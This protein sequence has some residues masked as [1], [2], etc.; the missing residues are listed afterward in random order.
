MI[1]VDLFSGIGG[2]ALAAKAVGLQTVVF[3]EQDQ[4][5]KRVLNKNFKGI[6]VVPDVNEFDGTKY[7]GG[8]WT[9]GIPCQPFSTAGEKAGQS[10]RRFLWGQVLRVI[11]QGRP[12][13]FLL[14]N[15][16]GFKGLAADRVAA[17]L[18]GHGYSTAAVDLPAA[19]VGAPHRRHRIFLAAFSNS[20][21]KRGRSRHNS[22]EHAENAGEQPS[23]SGKRQG[24]TL[25]GL[26]RVANGLP[27]WMDEPVPRVST[28]KKD[29]TKR[30]QGIGNAV[31]PALAA[32]V[33]RTM[34]LAY[35]KE[36]GS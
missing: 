13:L 10:D 31:V 33:M 26:D 16:A 35:E 23:N 14:E 3:C 17:D 30:L 24:D 22:R 12:E 1:H 8:F 25:P 28:G 2:F 9:A 18:E 19:C 7:S 27:G 6:Q 20:I 5:C 32:V 29:R 34:L 36:Q 21:G 11:E 4:F 15:V